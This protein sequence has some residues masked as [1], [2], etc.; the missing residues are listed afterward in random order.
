MTFS[1]DSKAA[2]KKR[3]FETESRPK[4]MNLEPHSV[5]LAIWYTED[6]E[7]SEIKE[8]YRAKNVPTLNLCSFRS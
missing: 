7:L 6:Y 8:M 2:A 5:I 4:V 1:Y 3:G